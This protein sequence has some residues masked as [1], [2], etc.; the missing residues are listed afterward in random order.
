MMRACQ[1]V[2]WWTPTLILSVLVALLTPAGTAQAATLHTAPPVSG[3]LTD[4]NISGVYVSGISSGGY[5]AGQLHVAYS[6]KI[7]GAAIFGAGPYYC[8]QNNVYQALYGCGDNIYPTY[9]ST[10][11]SRASTWSAYGWI[12]PVSNLSGSPVYLYQGKNDTTVKPSVGDAGKAFYQHFGANVTYD[13]TSA[14]GHSW[15]TPY[16]PNSCTANSA[17]YMN[18]CGTDPQRALLQKLFGSVS[19]PNTGP[20]TGKLIKFGQSTHAVNG[21]AS[22]L[23][24]GSS[25][26]AYV[27]KSCESDQSCRLMVS[28]HGCKQG[29]DKIGTTFVDRANLNQYADN[30]KMIVLYPQATSSYVN[31]NGCWDWWGYLGATNYPIQGGAQV[32]TIMNMVT[33]LGG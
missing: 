27:P 2:F 26:F 32:E 10:L 22:G 15:V 1:R 12:D 16:G 23:S 8:A 31:P 3:S 9:L 5:M 13:N 21:W 33:A 29:Y 24:M 11:T 19:S 14:A 17:P 18:N 7:K 4:H 25:G 20:L 28:L 6:K 30:N